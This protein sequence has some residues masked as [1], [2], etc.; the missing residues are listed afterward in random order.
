MLL[1]FQKIK[2][3]GVGYDIIS[4]TTQLLLRK[5]PPMS[6]QKNGLF[7]PVM[8]LKDFQAK[9]QHEEF[10]GDTI[11]KWEA[12]RPVFI[13]IHQKV[14]PQNFGTFVLFQVG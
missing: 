5:S 13:E 7:A 6:E 10:Y 1:D 11:I 14:K 8:D 2:P 12:G 9:M 4:P 3:Q